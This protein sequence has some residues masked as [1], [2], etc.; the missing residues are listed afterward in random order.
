MLPKPDKN[1]RKKSAE[2]LDLVETISDADKL[3]KKRRTL[4][5]FL[6]LTIGLSLSFW[7]Y[8]QFKDFNFS[9]FKLPEIPLK[10]PTLPQSKLSLNIPE[11]WTFEILSS[12]LAISLTTINPIPYAKKYLPEGVVVTEKL[13]SAPD[14]LEINSQISTPKINFEIY[15]KIP[16]NIT[17]S[18]PEIDQFAK[19]VETYYWYQLNNTK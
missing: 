5:I 3:K 11:N 8:R 4:I 6:I 16:G 12:P 2:Q 14:S 10:L 19:L 9:Q 1:F 18:S 7:A 13:N 17:P 15:A